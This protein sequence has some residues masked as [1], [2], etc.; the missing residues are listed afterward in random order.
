MGNTAKN[1]L[2][3]AGLVCL[4]WALLVLSWHIARWAFIAA[5]W[6]IGFLIV[7]GVA[8]GAVVFGSIVAGWTRLKTVWRKTKLRV[9]PE[10]E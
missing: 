3:W 6:L 5:L 2:L 1:A 4:A 10:S 9:R 7:G 8:V